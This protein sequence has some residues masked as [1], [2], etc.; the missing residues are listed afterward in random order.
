LIAY[1]LDASGFLTSKSKIGADLS[2]IVMV[3]AAVLLTV[4]VAY[5]LAKRYDA[6]RWV[7]TTAV[8]LNAIPVVLF[9][10]QSLVRFVLPGVPGS[11]SERGHTLAAVH[12]LAGAIGVA[13]GLFIVIRG[14]QL[15]ARG[16]SL[17]RYRNLMRGAYVVYLLAVVLG[18][19]LY[20]VTYG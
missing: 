1:F 15:F 12:A 5:A 4:G 14:N 6:H 7:Q 10:I 17:A 8:G 16:E 20:I 18:I 3:V 9:M 2:L 19:T 13:M 11:L